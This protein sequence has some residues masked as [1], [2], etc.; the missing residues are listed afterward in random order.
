MDPFVL[1]HLLKELSHLVVPLLL[2]LLGKEE[3][4]IPGH[5]L[6]AEGGKQILFGTGSFQFHG[7][8]LHYLLIVTVTNNLAPFNFAVKALF[9]RILKDFSRWV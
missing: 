3:I 7:I 8:D 6:A 2:G 4:F 5:R 9:L 1:G